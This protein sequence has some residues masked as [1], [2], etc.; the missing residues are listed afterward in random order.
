MLTVWLAWGWVAVSM[1]RAPFGGWRG[2]GADRYWTASPSGSLGG[3]VETMQRGCQVCYLGYG[4][5]RAVDEQ[6]HRARLVAVERL[7]RVEG[8]A[9][10][11]VE[12][13]DGNLCLCPETGDL[14]FI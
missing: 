9:G 1:R 10:W 4:R 7:Y 14:P 6:D 13:A 2:W 5:I 12:I 8:I 3:T 11:A